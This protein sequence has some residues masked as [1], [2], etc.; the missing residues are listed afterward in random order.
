ML[1]LGAGL[2]ARPWRLPLPSSLR[3]IEV[4][5]GPILDYKHN[6]LKDEAP[7]CRLERMTADLNNKADR[8]RV[9]ESVG[10]RTLLLTEGLLFYLPADTARSLAQEAAGCCRWVMDISPNTAILLANGGDSMQQANALR[11]ETRLEGAEILELICNSGW[12]AAGSKTFAKDGVPYAAQRMKK[13]G[14][15]PDPN[16]PRLSADDPSGVWLFKRE[17]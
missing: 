14:W 5:F 15:A 1:C 12:L 10:N 13:N 16:G 6:I 9:F 3:W 17:T 2:D 4:D 8:T 11:H 7:R